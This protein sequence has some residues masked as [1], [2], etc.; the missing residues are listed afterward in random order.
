MEYSYLKKEL[1][2][3]VR[4]RL[5]YG[6]DFTDEEV[7]NAIDDVLLEQDNIIVYR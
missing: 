6:K 5:D 7:E 1:G 4:E 2:Q 3:K